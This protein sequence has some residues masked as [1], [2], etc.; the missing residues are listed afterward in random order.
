[1]LGWCRLSGVSWWLWNIGSAVWTQELQMLLS[2][3]EIRLHFHS[4]LPTLLP[5]RKWRCR[6]GAVGPGTSEGP[7]SVCEG[8][9]LVL[10]RRTSFSTFS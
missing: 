1:M 4:P 7:L 2:F 8:S 5:A 9:D 6:S 3:T 10:G